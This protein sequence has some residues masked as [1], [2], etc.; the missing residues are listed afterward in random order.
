M[1]EIR[2]YLSI[3][4]STFLNRLKSQVS[5]KP[6]KRGISILFFRFREATLEVGGDGMKF[7]CTP[8]LKTIL[9][10]GRRWGEDW[11]AGVT[12]ESLLYDWIASDVRIFGGNK[13]REDP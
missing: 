12:T 3:T 13:F 2:T 5:S 7:M 10:G 6:N 8:T 11:R 9:R 4:L 1:I